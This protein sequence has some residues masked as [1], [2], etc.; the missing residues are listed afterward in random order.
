MIGECKAI[1]NWKDLNGLSP[2]I[3]DTIL[4]HG[5]YRNNTVGKIIGVQ[6]RNNNYALI[7]NTIYIDY[8]FKEY[9]TETIEY[10][11]EFE[12]SEIISKFHPKYKE[13]K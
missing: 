12:K 3:G 1:S 5:D 2:K 8:N 9:I 6:N 11:H 10:R 13:I 4:I 7:L